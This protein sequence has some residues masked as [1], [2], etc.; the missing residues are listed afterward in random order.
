MKSRTLYTVLNGVSLFA[1]L[2]AVVAFG[3]GIFG[4]FTEHRLRTDLFLAAFV[5]FAGA[6]ALH[7]VGDIGTR[8]LRVE[9]AQR[10]LMRDSERSRDE[11]TAA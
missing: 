3:L 2:A 10:R 5:L 9:E 8:L 1:A 4:S 11:H 6:V 7:A